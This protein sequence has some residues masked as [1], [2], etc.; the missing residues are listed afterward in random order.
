[1]FPGANITYNFKLVW[2]RLAFNLDKRLLVMSQE[3]YQRKYVIEYKTSIPCGTVG[4]LM[5]QRNATW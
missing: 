3:W 1:M 2:T 4:N 5:T